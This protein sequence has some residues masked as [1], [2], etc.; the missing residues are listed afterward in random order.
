MY[1]K[2][3]RYFTCSNDILFIYSKGTFILICAAEYVSANVIFHALYNQS[4]CVPCWTIWTWLTVHYTLIIHSR[5][6]IGR[7]NDSCCHTMWRTTLCIF[8]VLRIILPSI[9]TID[10]TEIHMHIVLRN[11]LFGCRLWM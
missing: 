10:H 1:L 11:T 4:I 7:E 8:C 5:T 6:D 9:K 2:N 3:K